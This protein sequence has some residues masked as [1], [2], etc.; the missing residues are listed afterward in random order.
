MKEVTQ[1]RIV[2]EK[3][4]FVL[5]ITDEDA[6]ALFEEVVAIIRRKNKVRQW[7]KRPIVI[8]N[9]ETHYLKRGKPV[10]RPKLRI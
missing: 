7:L 10:K 8:F 3:I 6:L 5:A 9:A 1:I 4:D 2:G